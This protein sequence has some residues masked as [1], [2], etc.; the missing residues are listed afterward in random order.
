MFTDVVKSTTGTGAPVAAKT[1]GSG[2]V[3]GTAT[4][5]SSTSTKTNSAGSTAPMFFLTALAIGIAGLL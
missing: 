2:T 3:V 5:A 4:A 1:T